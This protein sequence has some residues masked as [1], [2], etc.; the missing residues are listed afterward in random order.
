[1]EADCN[2]VAMGRKQ[3]EEI[4]QPILTKMREC[5]ERVSAE[6]YKLDD[7][8]ARHFTR[9]GSNLVNSNTLTESFSICGSCNG[10]TIL[11]ELGNGQQIQGN[12]RN[13]NNNQ[14]S[15]TKLVHC[16]SCLTGLKLP[17]GVP[18]PST[19]KD[20]EPIKCPICSFQVIKINEGDGYNGNGYQL[21]PKCFND[22]PAEY[23]GTNT[24]GE[25]RCFNCTHPTCSIATG[26]RGSD[27]EIFPCPF[28]AAKNDSTG[29]ITLRKNSRG[30]ILS[31]SNNTSANQAGC[32]YIIWLPREAS[33]VSIIENNDANSNRSS[34]CSRCSNA[35]KVVRKLLFK[36]KPN[37][38]AQ[39]VPRE[40]KACVLCD[41]TLKSDFR[42]SIPQMNQVRIRGRQS[43]NTISTVRRG[44]SRST[45]QP[46]QRVFTNQRA[47]IT[48]NGSGSIDVTCYKCGQPGHFANSCTNNR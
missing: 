10:R 38:I 8:V 28:C 27:V 19:N 17:K 21:C 43:S 5:F 45:S 44:Q 23:G 39:G 13:N 48:S 22:A 46:R 7:A 15:K 31:C 36:W 34:S 41:E 47:N 11:K 20:N 12:R 26:T 30:H 2:A 29:K 35:N 25:F 18:T 1:M 3:K 9:L 42:I 33:S 6:A 24:S 14:R 40:L 16:L 32:E 4:M 37:S